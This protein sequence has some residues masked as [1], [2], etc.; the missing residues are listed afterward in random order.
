MRMVNRLGKAR[1][2]RIHA[3]RV[4]HPFSFILFSSKHI[5]TQPKQALF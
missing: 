5:P 2:I 3:G 4:N 1:I